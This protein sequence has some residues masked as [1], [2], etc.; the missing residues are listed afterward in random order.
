MFKRLAY[1]L[2][3]FISVA[4]AAED[5]KA[6]AAREELERQLTQMVGK[7]PTKVRIDFIG[8]E[9]PNYKIEEASFELDGR[10]LR[11]P[12]LGQLSDD[13]THLIWNG[14][15]TP[16]KHTVKVLVVFYNNASVVLSDEG[17]HKWRV[18]GDVS[19]DVNSGIE[20]RVQVKPT[21]D[22]KQTEVA[23][24]FKLAL[25]A[26]PVMIATL[27][28]GKMPDAMPKPV[29][30]VVDAGV[31]GPTPEQLAE[32][33]AQE[34]TQK[35]NSAA[36]AKRVADE[37]NKQKVADALEA[38]R[39]ADEAK[40]QK[41]AAA[42][43][44]RAAAVAAKKEKV[45]AALQAKRAAAEAK[46]QAALDA[47]EAKKQRSAEALEAKRAADEAKKQAAL[48]AA[49]EKKRLAQAALDAKNPLAVVAVEPAPDAGA[50]AVAEPLD[51]GV[52][53]P[54]DA[55]SRV[56]VVAA[57]VDAGIPAPVAVAPAAEEDGPP[58]LII[59]GAGALAALIFLI[60]VARRRARPPTLDD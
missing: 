44:A 49:E 38:K 30:A 35:A 43:E 48:D 57:P 10:T 13:G 9:D 2:L 23:K 29:I 27:D 47:A 42:L 51:A 40:K 59:G 17:G 39:A 18:G 28:D 21:R 60:V 16:G 3:L 6:K 31:A 20:V 14:D 36:E 5:A 33:A 19:F 55:G 4:A 37:A 8:L 7:Q 12:P 45:A 58:W 15:V 56:E 50:V 11:T 41:A 26:Q 53:E 25:P 46:K 1:L 24:R 54:I 34:K 22:D 52:A 32:V